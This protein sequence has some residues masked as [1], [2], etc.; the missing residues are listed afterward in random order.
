M[1]HRVVISAKA[2]SALLGALRHADGNG[3]VFLI[4]F[5]DEK[6][7]SVYISGVVPHVG[8]IE[9]VLDDHYQSQERVLENVLVPGLSVVGCHASQLDNSTFKNSVV[10]LVSLGEDSA[11]ISYQDLDRRPVQRLEQVDENPLRTHMVAV[12]SDVCLPCSMK[13]SH[14]IQSFMTGAKSLVY[15]PPSVQDRNL[16]NVL[17]CDCLTRATNG[18]PDAPSLDIEKVDI[19]TT[20]WTTFNASAVCLVPRG[21]VEACG[22][23]A[24]LLSIDSVI[25]TL[26]NQLVRMQHLFD[27]HK[28]GPKYHFKSFYFWPEA[29]DF[30]IC[31]T[32]PVKNSCE[33][34][35]KD[36]A[37]WRRAAQYY[38]GLD[39][40]QPFLRIANALDVGKGAES[41]SKLRKLRNVDSGLDSNVGT[42]HRI[43]GTYE[44]YHYMQDG[45]DDSGWGCAYRSL[46]TICSWFKLQGYSARDPP[47]HRETQTTLVA[48]G[49]KG[50]DFIGSKNWIGAIELGYILDSLYDVQCKVITVSDGCNMASVAR[51]IGQHFD[52][53]GTPIM[54]GGGVLAYTLLGIDYNEDTGDCAFL[55][56]DP[57]YTGAD[58]LSK[59]HKGKWVSWKT[60]GDKAAAGGDLFVS[61]AF[62]NLLCPQ[63]PTLV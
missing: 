39:T 37:M 23:S 14:Y 3:K 29:L 31:M 50:K 52:T 15:R 25:L 13:S 1:V 30:P 36:V 43:Q 18:E 56:L 33:D 47:S 21:D 49:D 4:G 8:P 42:V 16:G 34:D 61:G 32:Y 41:C 9:C 20:T 28:Y 5:A 6:D 27:S 17:L 53:Q 12:K 44:Y 24:S 54:I 11:R 48:L 62:Y 35:N 57:H 40:K 59:I 7:S 38:L 26:E 19:D 45:F 60:V 10:V 58:D 2:N 22:A 51:E 46:Q 63:R 55:I